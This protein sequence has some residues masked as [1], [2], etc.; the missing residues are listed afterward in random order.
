MCSNIMR[1][2]VAGNLIFDLPFKLL[3]SLLFIGT[4][5][6]TVYLILML[7]KILRLK[8]LLYMYV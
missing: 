5:Y 1:I 8:Y 2:Y 4:M 3:Y 7:V 6:T